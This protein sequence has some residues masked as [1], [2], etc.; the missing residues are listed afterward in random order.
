M[1]KERA[2]A[3]IQTFSKKIVLNDIE[4]ALTYTDLIEKYG[5]EKKDTFL[6]AT[7][8][9]L[10]SEYHWR[11]GEYTKGIERALEAVALSETDARF[12]SV[13]AQALMTV[14]S[15]QFFSGNSLKAIEYYKD[16]ADVFLS[17]SNTGAYISVTSNIGAVYADYGDKQKMTL[18]W[19]VP[20][21]TSTR[22]SS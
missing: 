19:I 2:T 9:V 14:G 22:S 8:K 4:A 21:S 5:S 7:S 18:L 1:K 16:A 20:Y 15:I 6:L 10:L 12:Q 3:T 13:Q 17:D 11:K